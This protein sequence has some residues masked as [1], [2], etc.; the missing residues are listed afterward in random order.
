MGTTVRPDIGEKPQLKSEL[1]LRERTS[2]ISTVDPRLRIRRWVFEFLGRVA[3]I[4]GAGMRN[5]SRGE[6]FL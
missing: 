1:P 2:I 5:S 6:A 3:Y 4:L